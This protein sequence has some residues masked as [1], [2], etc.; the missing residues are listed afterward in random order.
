MT[1]RDPFDAPD[2]VREAFEFQAQHN[3]GFGKDELEKAMRAARLWETLRPEAGGDEDE[4]QYA[5]VVLLDEQSTLLVYDLVDE[6]SRSFVAFVRG[7]F[8]IAQ[9]TPGEV[10]K[11]FDDLQVDG[12]R[13]GRSL[14]GAR[15]AFAITRALEIDPTGLARID[16]ARLK[17]RLVDGAIEV[18]REMTEEQSLTARVRWMMSRI[19]ESVRNPPEGSLKLY[20]DELEYVDGLRV[21]LDGGALA[22]EQTYADISYLFQKVQ[23][24]QEYFTNQKGVARLIDKQRVK[25]IAFLAAWREAGD[26][27]KLEHHERM[28]LDNL[29]ARLASGEDPEKVLPGPGMAAIFRIQASLIAGGR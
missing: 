14:I 1:F 15:V 12:T 18:D 3:L 10:G 13:H 20:A 8:G 5:Q 16:P 29:Q 4:E 24:Q 23:P 11:M 27:S 7:Y 19:S 26:P 6:I 17:V 25:V 21:R 9:G 22:D 28:I 2:A